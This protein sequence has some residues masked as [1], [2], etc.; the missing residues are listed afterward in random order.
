MDLFSYLLYLCNMPVLDQSPSYVCH[1]GLS[2]VIKW[3]L[4]NGLLDLSSHVS[5]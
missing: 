3:L 4:M 5:I 2:R 1:I